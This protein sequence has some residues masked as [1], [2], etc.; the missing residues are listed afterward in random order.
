MIKDSARPTTIKTRIVA[1]Q[2]QIVRVDWESIELLD[3]KVNTAII[4]KLK[5]VNI[6]KA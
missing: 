6:M 1:G 2:Q 3:F 4:N 5:K